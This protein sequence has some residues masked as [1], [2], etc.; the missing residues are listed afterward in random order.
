MIRE[1]GRIGIEMQSSI[2]VSSKINPL[3]LLTEADTGIQG[4]VT[5]QLSA[6]FPDVHLVAEEQ[7]DPQLTEKDFFVL[8]PIDGTSIYANGGLD[9]GV[10]FAY[11]KSGRP[12]LGIIYLPMRSILVAAI[13]EK[14]V[15]C[16]QQNVANFSSRPLSKSIVG[17]ENGFFIPDSALPFLAELRKHC[18][19]IRNLFSASANG[20]DLIQGLTGAYISFG[21]GKVWDFAATALAVEELGGVALSSAGERLTWSTVKQT[22]L[23]ARNQEIVDSLLA[24]RASAI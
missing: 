22:V 9:W 3:D 7:D 14:G 1:A 24:I 11:F 6:L 21:G 8:D 18:L 13:K 20:V 19:G 23:F 4:Y 12:A 10:H 2:T 16:N 5:R 17:A 15:R